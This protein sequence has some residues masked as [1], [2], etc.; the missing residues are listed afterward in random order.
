MFFWL[1]PLSTSDNNPFQYQSTSMA[2]ANKNPTNIQYAHRHNRPYKGVQTRSELAA[3][4]GVDVKALA[5]VNLLDKPCKQ[6]NCTAPAVLNNQNRC[7]LCHQ[8]WFPREHDVN[9][10]RAKYCRGHGLFGPQ[11]MRWYGS[12][13]T[14]PPTCCC[15]SQLCEKI[16]YSHQ[17]MFRLPQD[18][19]Q[20]EEAVRV[21]GIQSADRRRTIVNNP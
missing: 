12:G 2:A 16:G 1:G 19:I 3:L 14:T 15:D 18:R 20:C 5:L 8:S 6:K 7:I 21:L 17:G 10:N 9:G 4:L 13:R 11:F